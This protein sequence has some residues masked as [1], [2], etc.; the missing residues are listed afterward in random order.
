M[1]ETVKRGCRQEIGPR[2]PT[3]RLTAPRGQY[4][5][6]AAVRAIAAVSL[7]IPVAIGVSSGTASAPAPCTQQM[8]GGSWATYGEDLH[9]SQHQLAEHAI[10]PSN[11]STLK[12]AWITGDTGYQSPPPIV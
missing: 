6:S 7:A 1:P 12:R 3:F 2:P 10:N 5:R 11:V 9:G 4:M 8:A